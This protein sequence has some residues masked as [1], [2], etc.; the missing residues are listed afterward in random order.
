M[1]LTKE[2]LKRIIKEELDA[3]VNEQ[4]LDEGLFD[5]FKGKKKEEP[6]PENQ[7]E[8][9]TTDSI[10]KGFLAQ[11]QNRP[12]L[13][14]QRLN[15]AISRAGLRQIKIGPTDN[16]SQDPNYGDL[17][18]FLKIFDEYALLQDPSRKGQ[19]DPNGTYGMHAMQGDDSMFSFRRPEGGFYKVRD[20]YKE[21]GN[22]SKQ[23]YQRRIESNIQKNKSDLEALKNS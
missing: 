7:A 20:P 4:D 23:S 11:R 5:F 21:R 8:M 3:V 19:N 9:Y 16:P 18:G 14:K 17:M 2:T 22:A 15:D 1:K 13:V 12:R 10:I 6:Q